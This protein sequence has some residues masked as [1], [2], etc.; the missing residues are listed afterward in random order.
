MTV[1]IYRHR[2]KEKS[3]NSTLFSFHPS[4]WFHALQIFQLGFAVGDR[5]NIEVG[6]SEKTTQSNIYIYIGFSFQE[7]RI[8]ETNDIKREVIYLFIIN[9][10]LYFVKVCSLLA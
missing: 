6:F 8:M 4:K 3:T 2:K 9:L 1:S 7:D 5:K 10:F